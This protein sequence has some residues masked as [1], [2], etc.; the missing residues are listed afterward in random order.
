[1]VGRLAPSPTGVLHLGNARTFLLAWLSVRAR[2]GTLLLRIEDIDQTRSR[3]A[4]E[5]GIYRD[6][7][8]L[9]VEWETPVRRQSD[10]M[11]AYRD[12]LDRLQPLRADGLVELDAE[13]LRASERGKLLLRH[14][15]M[16][17]DRYLGTAEPLSRFSKA[18]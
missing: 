10:H 6:L 3:P 9:G 1:M 8:W 17:F 18:I 5:A 12:A 4:F 14:V 2:G 15:A 11:T 13:C 16:C 7:E